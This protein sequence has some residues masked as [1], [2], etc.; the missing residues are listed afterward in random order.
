MNALQ[1][2]F[3]RIA[4][5][6]HL[7]DS[8]GEER[9]A[10]ALWASSGLLDLPSRHPNPPIRYPDSPPQ[11]PPPVPVDQDPRP[12]AEQ[13]SKKIL[14]S[15]KFDGMTDRSERIPTP[16]PDTFK[17]LFKIRY[18]HGE[19]R[20]PV[21]KD[22]D[23][24]QWLQSQNKVVFWITGKPASGKSTLMKFISTRDSLRSHL[25]VWT[26][27]AEL[28][29]ASF[30][31]W[32]PGSKIQK[33][34]VGLLRSLL[35]QLLS[36]RPD[37]CKF[38]A[39]RRRVLFGLAGINVESPAWDWTELRECLL[40]FASLIKGESRLTLFIDGLDEYDGNQEQLVAFLKKLHKDHDPKLCVSSRPWNIFSDAFRLSPSLTMEALT[41]PDIDI[42]VEGHLGESVAI[43]QLRALEPE[44]INKLMEEVRTRAEGVFLW[45]VLV[46]EQLVIT[47]RDRPQL[48]V[49]WEVF[50]G[51]PR[52][53]EKL[54]D[55]I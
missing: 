49:V 3:E 28:L 43:Q 6:R 18:D 53:L 25:H 45:V 52:G 9:F 51:L 4:A 36:Q 19:Q 50:N 42:Y 27:Y 23:F 33:S 5:G 13:I 21:E 48:S 37:L 24:M 39:L 35:H 15:L 10:D 31:F 20:Q 17:W 22:M 30:Y 40:R 8:S 12:T 46:V 38:V 26:G 14:E 1:G 7:A 44:S 34:R 2:D 16:Y 54:Y 11:T 47:A 55:I 41:Q 29:I 32:G